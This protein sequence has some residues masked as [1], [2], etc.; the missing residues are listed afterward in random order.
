MA[1]FFGSRHIQLGKW[2]VPS[3]LPSSFFSLAQFSFKI[4]AAAKAAESKS[5]ARL[6]TNVSE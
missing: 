3:P 2:K 1:Q 4:K 6:F 5:R